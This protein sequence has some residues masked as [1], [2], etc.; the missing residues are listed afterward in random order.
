MEDMGL[1]K[2]DLDGRVDDEPR[3]IEDPRG[4]LLDRKGKGEKEKC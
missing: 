3:D 4:A 1:H 2:N